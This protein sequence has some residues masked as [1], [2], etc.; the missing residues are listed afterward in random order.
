MI[1]EDFLCWHGYPGR[2][3]TGFG[4]QFHL[5]HFLHHLRLLNERLVYHYELLM[6]MSKCV[7]SDRIPIP[8]HQVLVYVIYIFIQSKPKHAPQYLKVMISQLRI[9]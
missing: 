4:L 6:E 5:Q 1:R 8:T 7:I 9:V 3:Y 2:N